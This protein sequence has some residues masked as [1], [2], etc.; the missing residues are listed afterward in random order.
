MHMH[1]Q[2]ALHLGQLPLPRSTK[3]ATNPS[4]APTTAINPLFPPNITAKKSLLKL[5]GRTLLVTKIL[6]N[7]L[8]LVRVPTTI[9]V[10]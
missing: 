4:P 1:S 2:A 5:M 7:A 3:P 8:T 10:T 6:L 9:A